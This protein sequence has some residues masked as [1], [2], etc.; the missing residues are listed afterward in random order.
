[1]ISDTQTVVTQNGRSIRRYAASL[2]HMKRETAFPPNAEVRERLSLVSHYTLTT[3]VIR[4]WQLVVSV[5]R[6]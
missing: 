5:G 3:R 6:S 1:M 4:G 2:F